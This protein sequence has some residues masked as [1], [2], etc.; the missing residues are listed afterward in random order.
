M[1][2]FTVHGGHLGP[3]SHLL[4]VLPG[5]ASVTLTCKSIETT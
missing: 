3:R 4:F 1:P 2:E 5:A